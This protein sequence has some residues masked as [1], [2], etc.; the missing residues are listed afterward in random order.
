MLVESKMIIEQL[1]A[2]F[3]FAQ[4]IVAAVLCLLPIIAMVCVMSNRVYVGVFIFF[5]YTYAVLSF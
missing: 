1:L 4:A 5:V 2:K 3:S